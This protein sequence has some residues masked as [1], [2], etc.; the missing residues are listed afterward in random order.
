MIAIATGNKNDVWAM[1]LTSK[2]V[3]Y[4]AQHVLFK[5]DVISA[6]PVDIEYAIYYN[7][8]AVAAGAVAPGA[9]IYDRLI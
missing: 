1:C 9:S 4:G 2:N 8:M 6:T 3:Q 7:N 5:V